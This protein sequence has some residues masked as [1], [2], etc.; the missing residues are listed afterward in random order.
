MAEVNVL[1][2]RRRTRSL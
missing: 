2:G 1:S